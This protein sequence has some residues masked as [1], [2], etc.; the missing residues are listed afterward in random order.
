MIRNWSRLEAVAGPYN[1][2]AGQTPFSANIGLDY[3]PAGLW[4][5]GF[6][7]TYQGASTSRAAAERSSYKSAQCALDLY[8]LWKI[9]ARTKL[10]MSASNLP[11]RDR[12]TA[13][14][15]A[16]ANGSIRRSSVADGAAAARVTLEQMF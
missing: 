1:R 8:A 5:A 13:E 14:G 2:L 9:G 10:R 11:P 7:V 6:N 12:R 15:Y 16:D 4:N 3:R